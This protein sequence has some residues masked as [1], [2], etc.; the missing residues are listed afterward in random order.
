MSRLLFLAAGD[1]HGYTDLH[2]RFILDD[3]P[4]RVTVLANSATARWFEGRAVEL[5]PV[6]WHDVEAIRRRVLTLHAEQPFT[7]LVTI[8]ER[9]MELAAALRDE[10][11]LPGLR[12]AD[13]PRFRDKPTMKRVLGAAGVRVP[14]F[15][16]ADDRAGVEALLTRHERIVIKPVDG[17]GSAGVEFA[18]T[19][20]DVARWYAAHP[21]ER[22]AYEAEEFIAGPMYH[23]NAVV[24]GGRPLL[25]LAAPYLPGMAPVDFGVGA[26]L[27]SVLLDDSPLQRRLMDF[28]DRVIE[29]LGLVDGVTHLECFVTP[30]D[31]IV[32]CE[33]AARPAAGGIVRMMEAR[34]GVNYGRAAVLLA[35]GLGGRIVPGHAPGETVGMLGF[36]IPSAQLVRRIA[37][38]DEFGD[39]WIRYRRIDGEAGTLVAGASHCTDFVGLFVFSAADRP[40]FERRLA[41]LRTRF[42][43]RLELAPI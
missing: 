18:D 37:S 13:V 43:Q 20:Q 23:V 9:M 4:A 10:L 21:G 16:H 31:E 28:S 27:A 22:A 40:G 38:A 11:G 1:G 5:E 12:G 42:D 29:V 30:G 25:T 24:R 14:E 39:P 3:L 6:R 15:A 17:M 34:S 7:A 41:E 32:F 33:I 36:R 35:L 19:V 26:P 2:D 8:D